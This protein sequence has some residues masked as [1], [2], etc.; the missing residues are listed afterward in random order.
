MTQK[1]W[2]FSWSDENGLFGFIQIHKNTEHK[3][4]KN[5]DH[6]RQTVKMIAKN[7]KTNLYIDNKFYLLIL[8]RIYIEHRY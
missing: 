7:I 8:K 1:I 4:N 3:T 2:P 6:F 5:D